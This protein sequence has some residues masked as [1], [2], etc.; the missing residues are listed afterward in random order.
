MCESVAPGVC[1]GV[2][3]STS[4]PHQKP[5]KPPSQDR[6]N[7]AN[8]TNIEFTI[9]LVVSLSFHSST[10]VFVQKIGTAAVCA[11]KC[12]AG[13]LGSLLRAIR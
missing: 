12:D 7:I 2:G 11:P 5:R 8:I 13:T 4:F 10:A 6:I 9:W 3:H 1:A